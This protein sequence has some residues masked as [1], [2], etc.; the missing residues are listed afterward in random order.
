MFIPVWVL[1]VITVAT[2]LT[3]MGHIK[4]KEVLQCKLEKLEKDF[5]NREYDLESEIENLKA[6]YQELKDEKDD[7]YPDDLY[8]LDHPIWSSR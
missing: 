1:I 4:D 2:V 3:I 5:E 8:P 6:D 7:S